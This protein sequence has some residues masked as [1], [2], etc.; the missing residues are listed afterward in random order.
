MRA[1]ARELLINAH[2][3][4]ANRVR[5]LDQPLGNVV[6]PKSDLVTASYV[7]NELPD[8]QANTAALALWQAANEALVII[9]PGTPVA[10]ERLHA[11][12][13]TLIEYGA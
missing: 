8:A 7:L 3:P 11:I 10:F 5:W 6:L 9:E 1:L 12:R 13:A 4:W 2:H